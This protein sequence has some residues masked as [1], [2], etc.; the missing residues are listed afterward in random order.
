MLVNIHDAKTHFSKYITQALN[1]EEIIVAKSG[2]PL[3]RL[4]PYTETTEVR[5]GGQFR[6]LIEISDDFDAP[7]PE[8]LL[9]QFYGHDE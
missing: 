2:K 8:N 7:L 6:G 3:I 9:N 4:I 1:G 5:H